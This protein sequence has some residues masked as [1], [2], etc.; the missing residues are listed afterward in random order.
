MSLYKRGSVWWY[1]FYK[2]GKRFCGSTGVTDRIEAER[3][4][5][6][7]RT[8]H[9]VRIKH[10]PTLR[11]PGVYFLLSKLTGLTKIGCSADVEFRIGEIQR[12]HPEEL[13]VAAIIRTDRYEQ[14]ATT[15]HD[16]FAKSHVRNEWF[17]LSDEDMEF[18]IRFWDRIKESTDIL[19]AHRSLP[20][21][22]EK[23]FTIPEAAEVIQMS[24]HTVRKWTE[25]GKIATVKLGSAVR[26]EARELRRFIDGR[27]V[28]NSVDSSRAAGE[29]SNT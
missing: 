28:A 29:V 3:I 12:S 15:L 18:G 26:I 13:Q 5:T 27:R 9:H 17:R 2:D 6:Q 10:K 22:R 25:Q 16:I 14:A 24:H 21:E 19:A 11:D 7:L 8:E 20:M 4:E 1:Q 23:L